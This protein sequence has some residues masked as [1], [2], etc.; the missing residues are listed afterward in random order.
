MMLKKI[1]SE[2]AGNAAVQVPFL[3][4]IRYLAL[5]PEWS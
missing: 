2:N 5:G 1:F 4:R 3:V